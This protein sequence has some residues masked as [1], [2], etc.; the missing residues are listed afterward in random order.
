MLVDTTGMKRLFSTPQSTD[1]FSANT[2]HATFSSS[3]ELSGSGPDCISA[4]RA[5][6]AAFLLGKRRWFQTQVLNFLWCAVPGS[7]S[8]S[9]SF[10]ELIQ[11]F[12]HLLHR[13][14]GFVDLWL[15]NFTSSLTTSD[16]L[17][18]D[19]LSANASRAV[20]TATGARIAGN[21]GTLTIGVWSSLL[22]RTH[23]PLSPLHPR[24]CF[25]PVLDCAHRV[26][27]PHGQP[28]KKG[29]PLATG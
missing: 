15:V 8:F 14:S 11:R 28:T 19:Q 6:R 18:S 9:N 24:A 23:P 26:S 16:S 5:T 10:S 12:R 17:M 7:S 21:G 25:G 2:K 27:R 29:Q 20:I 3:H 1:S 13:S 22:C 4:T